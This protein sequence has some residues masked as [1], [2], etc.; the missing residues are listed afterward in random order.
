MNKEL[1][2][3]LDT[4][5][6]ELEELIH[7][8][9]EPLINEVPFEG[10]WTPG[11]VADHILKSQKGVLQVLNGKT[12]V[13]NRKPDEYVHG[14]KDV[15]M[16]FSTKM[17]SPDFVLPANQPLDKSK[18]LERVTTARK[19]WEEAMKLDLTLICLDAILPGSPPMTRLEWSSFVLFHTKR[20]N[21]QLARMLDHVNQ[22]G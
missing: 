8:F 9:M 17:K 19:G 10:S 1:A 16:D 14:L 12:E 15:F 20:H 6:Q 22:L 11:Q 18:L 21:N 5:F 3:Q 2:T 7:S 13:A 4:A